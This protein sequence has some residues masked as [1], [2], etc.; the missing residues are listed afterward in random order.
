MR[1]PSATRASVLWR[2]TVIGS[3]L[4]LA[5]VAPLAYLGWR[6]VQ[7][8]EVLLNCSVASPRVSSV[9][10]RG[11]VTFRPAA[12]YESGFVISYSE[13]FSAGSVWTLAWNSSR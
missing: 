1:A 6:T 9:A 4:V 12:R 7:P 5:V 11:V 10:S 3:A 13:E 2:R 8:R